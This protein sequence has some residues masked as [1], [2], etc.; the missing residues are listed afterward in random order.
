MARA[1][2]SVMTGHWPGEEHPDGAFFLSVAAQAEGLGYDGVFAGDHLVLDTP[3]PDCLT[4][5]AYFAAGSRRLT[6]GSM[7][8]QLP[9]R[10]LLVTAKALS[11]L[12]KLSGGRLVVG[13]GVGGEH[14]REWRG[15]GVS[16]RERGA[17]M[18]AYLNVLPDLLSGVP[19][20]AHDRFV[21][22]DDVVLRPVG[23]RPQG[24]PI[25]IG[26]RGPAAL[27]RAS[28][29]DGW[30]AYAES[31]GGFARKRAQIER[32]RTDDPGEFRCS[33]MLFTYVDDSR[34]HAMGEL[35]PRLA[36]GYGDGFTSYVE[37]FCAVGTVDDV[38][39][40]IN[41]Y[42]AAGATDVILAPQCSADAF[43]EQIAR[44]AE[45][46]GL[47]ALIVQEQGDATR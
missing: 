33:Y 44:L 1:R 46:A 6:I 39:E 37:K 18:D 8:L 7:V 3:M 20:S 30:C 19:V 23:P 14:P 35:A 41:E 4:T 28:R 11:T 26:G 22:L 16:R 36:L 24:P 5:L 29:F 21:T 9:L 13:T 17:R 40:R 12:D 42:I 34:K 31:V 32:L 27:A 25:W 2:F 43:G 15:A 47:S 10:P 38:A 45:A